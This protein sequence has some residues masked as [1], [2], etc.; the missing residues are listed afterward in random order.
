MEEN[1]TSFEVRVKLLTGQD[2]L[3]SKMNVDVTFIGR[4]L[5]NSLLVPTVA[6][7]TQDGKQGVMIPGA[8]NKPEFKPVK[9]GLYLGDKTQIIEGLA[10]NDRVFIDLPEENSRNRQDRD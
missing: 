3:R 6:I 8:A 10:A 5:S 1:V 4:E 9:V 7:F 2:I